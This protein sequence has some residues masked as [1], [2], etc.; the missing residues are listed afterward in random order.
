MIPELVQD[1]AAGRHL[2]RRRAGSELHLHRG[3]AAVD[4]VHPGRA[5]RQSARPPDVQGALRALGDRAEF[6]SRLFSRP[7][8]AGLSAASTPAELFAAYRRRAAGREALR[9]EPPGDP[10]APDEAARVR[11]RRG[12]R[13]RHRVRLL[14]LLRRGAG[15]DV[16]LEQRGASRT[17][18][19][20]YESVQIGDRRGGHARGA[21]CRQRRRSRASR[22]IRSATSSCPS[23]AISPARRRSPRLPRT[24][25]SGAASVTTFYTSN[26]EQYL[27]QDGIWDAFR[28]NVARMPLDE[29]STFIRSCFNSCSP[30]AGSRAV[31]LLD[32]MPGLLADAAGRPHSRVL[33]RAD[34]TR[35]RRAVGRSLDRPGRRLG[36][37]DVARRGFA[38]SVRP[39]IRP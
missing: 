21:I 37:R 8:P 34:A 24:C 16:C 36:R 15:S 22:A 2:P 10:R 20:S 30:P 1:G 25:A 11:A 17:A 31:S 32:S 14:E 35:G 39:T 19:P 9:R 33:G 6:L 5:P 28:G 29:T 12:R 7:R 4:G 3:S 38:R 23:S 18:I 13:G 27:F 26:V